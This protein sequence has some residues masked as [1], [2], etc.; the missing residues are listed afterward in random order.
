MT[1]HAVIDTNVLV[2]SLLTKNKKAP[3]AR[4]VDALI[5]D[6][7]CPV[8]NN[9]IIQEYCEVLSRKEFEFEREVTYWHYSTKWSLRR[10]D[11]CQ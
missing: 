8:Y 11:T 3:T 7:F 1:I 4:L 2:S 6:V 9:D 10:A 5:D